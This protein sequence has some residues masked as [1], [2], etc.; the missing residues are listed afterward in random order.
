MKVSFYYISLLIL[1]GIPFAARSQKVIDY[2]PK[3]VIVCMDGD[4]R[5]LMGG[6]KVLMKRNDTLLKTLTTDGNGRCMILKPKPGDY[7]ITAIK[8]NYFT[9]SLAHV[10]VPSDQTI[11][12]EIPMDGKPDNSKK[13]SHLV[14]LLE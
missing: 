5:K 13:G 9:F 4:S 7:S 10:D 3:I 8:A 2:P 14:A 1:L 12:L 11:V 6:V